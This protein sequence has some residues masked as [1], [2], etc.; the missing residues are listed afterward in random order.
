MSFKICFLSFSHIFDDTRIFHKE[1]L[2]LVKAGYEVIHIAPAM[3]NRF[4]H[5]ERGVHIELYPKTTGLWGRLT[6]SFELYKRAVR[7]NADCYHCNEVESWIV[8]CLCKLF[9]SH[10]RIIFD[11]HEYYPGRF[12]E[13]H[14]PKWS[15][16]IGKPVLRLLFRALTPLTDFLIFAKR[17]VAQDFYGTEHKQ[18]F[19]FNYASLRM[20]S[21]RKENVDPFIRK[22]FE[23]RITAIHIGNLSRSRGWPQLLQAMVIM[24]HQDLQVLCLGNVD[25][26]EEALLIEA[27]RLGIAERIQ[28]K[29]RMPYERM[30]D[31]L[32]CADIGLM[33]YQPDIQNHIFAFPIKM[34]DY[35]VAGLPFIGPDFAVEVEPV[36]REEKC[37]LLMNTAQPEEIAQALDWLCDNPSLARE[38]GQRGRQAVISK[39]NWEN[40]EKKLLNIYEKILAEHKTD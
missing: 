9:H 33:L 32:L 7:I 37:G 26:G 22:E 5:F 23:S 4:S 20:Q 21:Y 35:M 14:F 34:Y 3:D 39:Y 25:E 28:I 29:Q 1:A 17:S 31:Y 16:W 15:R 30:F 13:S 19:I 2:S 8:G 12:E 24:R 10:K 38:M 40:E 36:V 27:K 11:V 18:E 6:K